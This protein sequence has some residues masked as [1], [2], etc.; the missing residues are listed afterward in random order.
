MNE[1]FPDSEGETVCIR[2]IRP[3]SSPLTERRCRER[4]VLAD[5]SDRRASRVVGDDGAT[6]AIR[7]GM[8]K[9]GRPGEREKTDILGR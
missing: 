6:R 1:K 2:E 8:D 9:K 3:P 5:I 7:A 4:S